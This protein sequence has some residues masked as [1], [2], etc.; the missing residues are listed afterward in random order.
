MEWFIIYLIMK[1]AL[2]GCAVLT[3]R[4]FYL[5]CALMIPEKKLLLAPVLGNGFRKP[6][7]EGWVLGYLQQA[8]LRLAGPCSPV[9]VYGTQ[10]VTMISQSL[11]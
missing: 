3:G 11:V 9:S 7:R 2:P 4:D 6:F 8:H 10:A 5:A 1:S